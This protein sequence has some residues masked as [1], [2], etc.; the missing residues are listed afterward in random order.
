MKCHDKENRELDRRTFLKGA[1][2]V[3]TGVLAAAALTACSPES[4][5]SPESSDASS[6]ADV[7][8]GA[9]NNSGVFG[10]MDDSN[11][12]GEVPKI[13]EADIVE[14]VSVD[15]VVCGS[16]HAGAY[17]A[18]MAAE[19]GAS[20]AVL[21]KSP[22][23]E[24][25]RFLGGE[26]GNFNSRFLES[27][28]FGGYDLGQITR[29]FC[30]RGGNRVNA[31][32]VKKYVQNSG[33]ALDKFLEPIPDD[34]EIM[35]P[36][37]LVVHVAYGHPTA[38]D[39][40][41]YLG[42]YYTW[43]GDTQFWGPYNDQPVDGVASFSTIT[44]AWNYNIPVAEAAGAQWY[45]GHAATVCTQ[46]DSGDVTGVIAQKEDGSYVRFEAVKAV[47]LACGDFSSN[48]E[49]VWE[50]LFE[51]AEENERA[52]I[53][54]EDF[55][56]DN[57]GFSG[58]MGDGHK[59]G[60]WAG[61]I[62]EPQPRGTMSMGGG[63]GGPWGTSPFL[64][65]NS[66]GERFMNEAEALGA[67]PITA[68]Q[69]IGIVCTVTD[70]KFIQSVR[71]AS[72]DHGAP[73]YA[74]PQYYDDIVSDMSGAVAAG[75]QGVQVRSA[76]ITE[77]N[78]STVFGAETLEDA[79]RFAGYGDEVIPHAIEQINLYNEL[80]YAGQDSDFGKDSRCLLAVDEPPFYT[81][82]SNN[83][84]TAS[85][86]LVTLCGLVTDDNM[87][88]LKPDTTPIKGL[89]AVGNCLGGRW[90]NAYSTPTGGASIGMAM[91]HGYV[92]GQYLAKI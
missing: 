3:G 91:T 49:M 27:R 23:Q 30:I 61:G 26:F 78:P 35:S 14:T 47:V 84:G 11:W 33:P 80:C 15:I 5:G 66:K 73:N 17:T 76:C 48:G 19:G 60:C 12:L 54:K 77:R 85:A 28:G 46:N 6:S 87:N 55:I 88:V 39:Y 82:A 74:R 62:I 81:S 75:A 18:L 2:M 29:E 64:W 7:S 83:A 63:G 59:M 58:G 70:S 13:N 45:W 24:T 53:S 65:L 41:I 44:K 4:S 57:F 8:N 71:L 79:L 16:G 50:L 31:N 69:P 37:Q 92:L 90:G 52:G 72:V 20:V 42:G 22:S 21:E 56:A 51:C 86:G 25:H 34:D 67:G 40:P 38:A 68:R 89:Y 1:G 32:L 10:Y 9:E 36:E 43:A